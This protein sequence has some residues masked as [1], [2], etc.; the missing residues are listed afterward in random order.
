MMNSQYLK[1]YGVDADGKRRIIEEQGGL[2]GNA[3]CGRKIDMQSALDHCHESGQTRSVLCDSCN[4]A[5]GIL[6][7]DPRRIRG[8]ADYAE[9]WKQLRLI[10]GGKKT[11]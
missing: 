1:K 8:L 5:L 9:R 6:S 4:T 7:E 3:K 10:S 11:A 2:C